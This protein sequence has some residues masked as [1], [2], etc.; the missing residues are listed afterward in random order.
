[1]TQQARSLS[2]GRLRQTRKRICD[3]NLDNR[4]YSIDEA[5]APGR[6]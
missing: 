5:L 6:L 3:R 4:H 1:M 2:A